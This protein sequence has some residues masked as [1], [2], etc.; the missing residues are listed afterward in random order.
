MEDPKRR[1]GVGQVVFDDSILSADLLGERRS[2]GC[3]Q[4]LG[5]DEEQVRLLFLD[6]SLSKIEKERT[7]MF[8]ISISA[9]F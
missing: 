5:N 2:A 4:V 6:Q 9:D 7:K 3:G 1:R 8:I